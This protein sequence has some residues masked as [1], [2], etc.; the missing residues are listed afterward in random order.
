[1]S[2]IGEWLG[3]TDYECP[4]CGRMRVESWSC[5][6]HICEK[7]HWCIEDQA[8]YYEDWDDEEEEEPRNYFGLKNVR[9]E[10]PTFQ[11]IFYMAARGKEMVRTECL[12]HIV[13]TPS[14]NNKEETNET[15]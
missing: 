13:F 3:Y 5:G 7:C 6:K 11:D 4:N 10:E 8:Y 12:N 1:M 15:I 9:K 14:C 2:K